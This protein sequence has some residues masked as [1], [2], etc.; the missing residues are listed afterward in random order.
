MNITHEIGPSFT[1]AT[2][3]TVKGNLNKLPGGGSL[4][5][6][7]VNPIHARGTTATLSPSIHG[8]NDNGA[9]D[10]QCATMNSD[11]EPT[12]TRPTPAMDIVKKLDKVH[13]TSTG[14]NK[15]FHGKV[16]F[17]PSFNPPSIFTFL[18]VIWLNDDTYGYELPRRCHEGRYHSNTGAAAGEKGKVMAT[19]SSEIFCDKRS[20]MY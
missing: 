3:A 11:D 6:F 13:I 4:I 1:Q 14:F 5:R 16:L 20:M 18:L 19:E 7:P 12:Y 17:A 10:A 8:W 9:T 2:W 15:R